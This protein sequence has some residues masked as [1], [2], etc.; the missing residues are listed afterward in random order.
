MACLLSLRSFAHF[1][2]ASARTFLHANDENH[3]AYVPAHTL[4][5]SG[6]GFCLAFARDFAISS[7]FFRLWTA[8]N[9]GEAGERE[10]GFDAGS[11]G[12]EGI[13]GMAD[14]RSWVAA[15]GCRDDALSPL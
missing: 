6:L 2:L 9:F 8:S 7:F 5:V 13:E 12:K 11:W 1:S 4:S 3:T 14:S 15:A 10:M